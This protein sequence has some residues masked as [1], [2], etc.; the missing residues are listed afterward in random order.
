MSDV[1]APPPPD[2]QPQPPVPPWPQAAA[3][4]ARGARTGLVATLT[5][6]GGLLV[7]A[8]VGTATYRLADSVLDP[9]DFTSS[10]SSEDPYGE[11]DEYGEPYGDEYGDSY[12]DP[13]GDE[14]EDPEELPDVLKDATG[15]V[16]VTSC[17]RD[18][19]IG[20]QSA[21]LK[22]VNST[23]DAVDY[24]VFVDFL[25]TKGKV[26]AQ[27]VT[28]VLDVA[29]GATATEKVQGLGEVPAGTT[30]EVSE[31]ARTPAAR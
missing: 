29:P 15:D 20:W 18:S 9:A 2:Q 6:V 4:S 19:T 27:G 28:G 30:C 7:M 12:D 23:D 31:V 3:P 17:V 1:F 8:A 5:A 26:V 13:Y 10:S 16:T 25:D 11:Y 14:Y 22:V 24:T 21:G